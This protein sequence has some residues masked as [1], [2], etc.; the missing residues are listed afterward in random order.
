MKGKTIADLAQAYTEDHLTNLLPVEQ[1]VSLFLKAVAEYQARG[2]LKQER[3]RIVKND[4]GVA[5][6]VSD[7]VVIDEASVIHVS[8]WGVIK[9][10]AEL[11][12]EKESAL[13]QE[14]SRNHSHDPYGRNSSEV[15]ADIQRYRDE[16]LGKL[17]FSVMATT[18]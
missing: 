15:E 18:I 8:D 10:L 17:A 14:A 9:V 5:L 3:Q 1:V 6:L 16:R 11:F 13:L 12:C 2:N 4:E 7:E